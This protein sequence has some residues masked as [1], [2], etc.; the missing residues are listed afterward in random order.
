MLW[1]ESQYYFFEANR[2]DDRL[3]E[4]GTRG[5]PKEIDQLTAEKKA[6][7]GEQDKL[8]EQAVALYKAII[9][10]YQKYPRLHEVLYF[11]TQNLQNRNRNDPEALRAYRALIKN[12]PK[13][14]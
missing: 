13:S 2:R 14:P 7:E 1:E 11:L 9:H 4:L 3:I 5:D 10:R 6:L 12:S 8:Q